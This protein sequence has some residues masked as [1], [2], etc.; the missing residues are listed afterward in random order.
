M[1]V[2]P[3]WHV[4][5]DTQSIADPH[6]FEADPDLDPVFHF[7]ADPD[8]SHPTFQF[9]S[10]PDLVASMLQNDP[11]R[12]SP[13]HFWCRSCFW[14][15]CGSGSWSNFALWCRTGSSV[16]KWCRPGFATPVSHSP[17]ENMLKTDGTREFCHMKTTSVN[18]WYYIDA[19]ISCLNYLFILQG[20]RFCDGHWRGQTETQGMSLSDAVF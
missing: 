17:N 15:R 4:L 18:S 8:P 6:H 10:D 3:D 14:L 16:P 13:F 9:D 1:S 11:L 2:R 5:D 12:L 7:D 20:E 19:L